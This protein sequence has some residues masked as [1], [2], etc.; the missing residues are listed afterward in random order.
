MSFGEE[1]I[2]IIENWKYIKVKLYVSI[3]LYKF[4]QWNFTCQISNINRGSTW[5]GKQFAQVPSL[6]QIAYKI[7]HH[8]YREVFCH[9]KRFH[10]TIHHLFYHKMESNSLL[11]T[12]APKL[13][14]DHVPWNCPRF[15]ARIM[16]ISNFNNYTF[17][18]RSHPVGSSHYKHCVVG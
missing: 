15:G 13:Q 11:G 12:S 10:W 18:L 7:Q 4:K 16:R 8:N 6:V 17:P 5:A 9:D 2:T 14:R 1:K 3:I